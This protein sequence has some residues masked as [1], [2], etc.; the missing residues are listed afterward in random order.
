LISALENRNLREH[1][2]VDGRSTAKLHQDCATLAVI[3]AFLDWTMTSDANVSRGLL[4]VIPLSRTINYHAVNGT[5]RPMIYAR[6]MAA[7][8]AVGRW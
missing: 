1:Q 3:D 4:T 5:T 7:K 6:V 2:H 8:N